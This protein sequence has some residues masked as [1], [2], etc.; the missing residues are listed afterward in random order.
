MYDPIIY[1]LQ[2]ELC[3][4]MSQPA[5]LQILHALFEGAKNVNDISNITELSQSVVSRH[6]G[7]LKHNNLL[8]SQ[9]SGQEVYYALANPKI[10]EVCNMMRSV[11]IE[12]INDRSNIILNIK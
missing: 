12:Q 4:S 5:R 7:I 2:A 9:R 3:Q 11:L 6:L 10:I 1:K 8:T